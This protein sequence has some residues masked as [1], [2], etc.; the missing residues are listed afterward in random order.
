MKRKDSNRKYRGR[1]YLGSVII[2]LLTVL[3]TGL[4]ST[5]YLDTLKRRIKSESMEHL[6]EISSQISINVKN[7]VYLS[8]SMLRS[9]ADALEFAGADTFERAFSYII[10]QKDKL[11]YSHF[12]FID[13]SNNYHED[14]GRIIPSDSI[15]DANGMSLS[16]TE[17]QILSIK[18]D[19]QTKPLLIYTPVSSLILDGIPLKAVG[20]TYDPG[21]LNR[22]LNVSAFDNAGY[23]YIIK[24]NGTV[25]LRADKDSVL[26]SDNCFD[27]LN[28]AHLMDAPD[29]AEVKS[30]LENRQ[31]G[32]LE[33]SLYDVH[34][35]MTYEPLEINDWFL[36]LVVPVSVSNSSTED[37]I[38]YSY[39]CCIV[40]IILFTI[41]S[42]VIFL[43]VTKSI[44]REKDKELV[45]QENLFNTI[46][47]II[48]DV[49]LIYDF[50]HKK[51]EYI[52]QNIY[53]ILGVSGESLLADEEL[54][55]RLIC[56]EN[57]NTFHR[58]PDL[59]RGAE[60]FISERLILNP[61]SKQKHWFLIQNYPVLKRGRLQM[62]MTVFSDH[63]EVKNHEEKLINAL[64]KAEKASEAKSLFLSKMSHEIRTP[65]NGIMGMITIAGNSMDDPNALMRC[66]DKVSYSAKFLLSL[67]ND[68]LDMSRIES[69]KIQLEYSPFSLSRIIEGIETMFH[70]TAET[71]GVNF[72]IIW[73][74]PGFDWIVGD[75]MRVNQ[76]IINLLSNAIKF[77][78]CDGS[79]TLEIQTKAIG[80]KNALPLPSAC[81]TPDEPEEN[82]QVTLIFRII[83]TGIGMKPEFLERIFNPFEQA[84][85]GISQKFGGTG[86]GLSICSN[87]V[88]MMS[89]SI[90][91]DSEEG[92]GSTFTVELTFDIYGAEGQTAGP[93]D[94]R[95]YDYDPVSQGSYNFSNLHV[96]LAEDNEINAE[97][98][99]T[100]LQMQKANVELATNG[101][102]AVDKWMNSSPNYYDLIL[103]DIQMPVMDG[104]TAAK[105]IRGLNRP[106]AASIPIYAMTANAFHE[107]V[108]LALA[109]GMNGHLAKP[110][111]FGRLFQ[112]LN[113]LIRK[114]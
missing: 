45:N 94:E 24:S 15:T 64:E 14:T 70:T 30:N 66:L 13:Q 32:S 43:L 82:K 111:E 67:I 26:E 57:E 96:L 113:K 71:K 21:I 41:L 17:P 34:K 5:S 40:L 100:M 36:Q 92:K 101:K 95:E 60:A 35:Y 108:E 52:S 91:V 12:Y 68:V 80:D 8:L 56:W 50:R 104:L 46:S 16:G 2:I 69:G 85:A 98:A 53:R 79:V 114:N 54:L 48:D 110:I 58:N 63:T 77:T 61:L 22:F 84:N 6:T 37:L 33:Y 76:I 62:C 27:D 38:Q 90:R 59:P 97:I 81:T 11:E 88:H 44:L 19:N 83:D 106:D 78:P 28:N 31:A 87:F 42:T 65:I 109:S 7:K 47:N 1:V 74:N 55:E 102:E 112:I 107:D 25:V 51:Y 23:C 86:L 93:A 4:F 29:L 18:M 103:M 99:I 20:I 72:N 10:T 49:F 89:G 73:E 39:T 9:T 105:T 75:E 3:I